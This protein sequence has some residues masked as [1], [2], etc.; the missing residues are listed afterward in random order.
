VNPP[1]PLPDPEWEPTRGF[2]AAAAR[3]ELAI[4]RCEACG[5]L[6]W[7]P[8]EACPACGAASLAWHVVSGRGALFSWAVVER[9]WVKEYR[10]IA[11][12]TTGIVTLE[13]D[14]SVR[15]VTLVVDAEPEALRAG[16]PMQ[17]VFR[18]LPYPDASADVPVPQFRPV[19]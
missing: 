3:G 1:F 8:P 2:F 4:P 15:L 11:P 12:Y 14:P 17:A 7:V 13:E 19:A 5:R 18:P 10:P 16:L 6:C 9:A